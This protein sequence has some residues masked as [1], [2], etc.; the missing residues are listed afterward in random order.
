MIYLVA[1]LQTAQDGNGV[2]HRR[3]IHLYRLE[4]SFQSSVLLDVLPVFI[5]SG[6]ADTVQL[7][8]CQHGFEHVSGVHAAL[9]LACAH[10][11]MQLVDEQNDLP[12]AVLHILQHRLQTLLK[13]APVLGSCHQRAHVQG[14]NLLIL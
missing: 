1:L 3:L 4:T 10:N 14:K 6:G 8:S 13:F 9:R 7:A 2:L 12:V 11:G 5:Q